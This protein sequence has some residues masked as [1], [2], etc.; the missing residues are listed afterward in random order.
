MDGTAFS[1]GGGPA[2]TLPDGVRFDAGASAP[3]FYPDGS[4]TGA[5]ITLSAP[6]RSRTVSVVAET[7][8]MVAAP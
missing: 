2:V 8:L 1:I 5:R 4:A 7:G 3:I 6:H